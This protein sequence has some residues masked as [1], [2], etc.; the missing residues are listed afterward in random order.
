MEEKRMAE[1]NAFD[2]IIGYEEIKAELEEIADVLK[3]TERY[4]RLGVRPPKGLLLSGVPGIGKTL[5][6]ECLIRASGRRA[7]TCRKHGTGE[8]FTEEIQKTFEEAAE[9]APSIVLLD[10]MDKYANDDEWHVNSSEYVTVQSCIDENCRKGVFVIATAN[11]TDNLPDSLIRSG[12]F[13]RKIRVQSPDPASAEKIVRHYL[14]GKGT[15]GEVDC[16]LIAAILGGASC[17]T[18]ETIVNEAG[19][20]A[21]I[22]HKSKIG[23]EDMIRACI[24]VLYDAPAAMSK[25]QMEHIGR[26]ACHEAGH[27]LVAEMQRPGSVHLVSVCRGSGNVNGVTSS[28]GYGSWQTKEEAEERIRVALAG[29]AATELVFGDPDT[30]AVCDMKQASFMIQDLMRT[31]FALGVEPRGFQ[32]SELFS[33]RKEEYLS[34][35]LERYYQETRKILAQNRDKLDRL[36]EK[37]EEKHTLTGKEIRDAMDGTKPEETGGHKSAA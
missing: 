3:E 28:G 22:G 16:G 12:R 1:T 37:L 4:A 9:A 6:A 31:L 23:M 20:Y 2:R 8:K 35:E 30:G 25:Q 34:R 21:G 36:T 14:K 26:I 33:A 11:D 18:L 27:A 19:I 10:D 32:S 7:F 17:A 29:K 5:M 15:V 24:R 13:D